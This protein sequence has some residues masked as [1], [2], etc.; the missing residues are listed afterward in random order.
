MNGN[1]A[2]AVAIAAVA[3]AAATGPFPAPAGAAAARPKLHWDAI[4]YGAKRRSD[5]RAYSRRHYRINSN[6]L[7]RP[8]VIVQH[9]S[10]G[11]TYSSA[12][13]TFA[14]NVRDGELGELPGVCAHFVVSPNGRIN[15]LVSLSLMC[16]HTVGLNWTAI[17][18]EHVGYS[19]SRVLASARM[20]RASL[21]LTNWLRCRYD[22]RLSNV[23]GHNESLRSPYHRE[24]VARLRRQTHGDWPTPKMRRYRAALRRLSC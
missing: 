8:K 9:M 24:R 13:N 4:P 23:I 6:R 3:L 22:I 1:A 18:I 5:M 17:G 11:P 16:R 2:S 20:R 7:N 12:W 14:P 15:Q 10:E 21:R 19:E